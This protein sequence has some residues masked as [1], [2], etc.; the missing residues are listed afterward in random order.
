M[1]PIEEIRPGDYVW[2]RDEITGRESWKIV[3]RTFEMPERIVWRISI[4]GTDGLRENLEVTPD[5]LFW[6]YT[7]WS[8]VRD[9]SIGSQ[10]WARGG[11]AT[12]AAVSESGIRTTVYNIEV[13][14]YHTYFVGTGE[15]WVHNDCIAA[16]RAISKALPT[17]GCMGQ[18]LEHAD[19]LIQAL[20]GA[21]IRGTELTLDVG[22]KF[23]FS[24][25]YGAL[26][27]K[28]MPH[29]AVRVGNLVFDNMHPSGIPYADWVTDLGGN[30]ILHDSTSRQA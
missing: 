14:E 27:A 20:K 7:G 18:C 5:H 17:A 4:V 21:G 9:L 8:P 1:K 13:D 16:A 22:N 11:W 29:K 15:I 24:N 25:M 26:G 28:G 2:S 12:V 19:A 23:V 30:S 3:V 10:V 6:K